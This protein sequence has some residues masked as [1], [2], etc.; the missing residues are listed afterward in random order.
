MSLSPVKNHATVQLAYEY[1]HPCRYLK[2]QLTTST[3]SVIWN[4]NNFQGKR[5]SLDSCSNLVNSQHLK[6]LY[7]YECFAR[8]VTVG[9]HFRHHTKMADF[10]YFNSCFVRFLVK[11]KMAKTQKRVLSMA[12][13]DSHIDKPQRGHP[14]RAKLPDVNINTGA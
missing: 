1:K 13:S 5:V 12:S 2:R 3:M 8:L 9:G 6:K 10:E 7:Q 14:K 4:R 11:K